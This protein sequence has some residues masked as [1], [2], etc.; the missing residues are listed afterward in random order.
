MENNELI[1]K[2][3]EELDLRAFERGT[4]EYTDFLNPDEI[5]TLKSLAYHG[6]YSLFGGYE[7]AER[8]V[9]AF[10]SKREYPI[11]C[12]EIKPK[13]KKFSEKLNHRDYLGTLLATGINRTML[14][15]I[16]IGEDAAYVFCIESISSYVV[17]EVDRIRRTAVK[18]RITNELPQIAGEKPE[19]S[20]INASSERLDAVCSAV[21]K[22]SRNEISRLI[23]SEKAFINS[24]LTAKESKPLCEGDVVSLRGYGRFIYEGIERKTKKDRLVIAVRIYK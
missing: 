13:S 16:L 10:G 1:K 17:N 9:A 23:T 22:L 19:V 15:D 3:F 24:R 12:I 11:K 2:R 7:N 18:C 6:E 8:C 21:F 14:G 5:S 20:Y 4:T